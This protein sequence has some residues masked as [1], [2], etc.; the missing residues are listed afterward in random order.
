[1]CAYIAAEMKCTREYLEKA[2]HVD[3][4]VTEEEEIKLCEQF[5]HILSM[6]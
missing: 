4:T 2:Y 3:L 1:M 5:P 6:P